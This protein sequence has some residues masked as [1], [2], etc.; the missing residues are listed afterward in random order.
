MQKEF[1]GDR[2]SLIG[3]LN[4]QKPKCEWS[5]MKRKA[6]KRTGL[7]LC[8]GFGTPIDSFDAA[9]FGMGRFRAFHP[10]MVGGLEMSAGAIDTF[11]V[12]LRF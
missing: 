6:N 8:S 3:E 9:R 11:E 10:H 2:F 4:N 12:N 1:I 7:E 5:K